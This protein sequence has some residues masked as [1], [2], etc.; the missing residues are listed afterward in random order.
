MRPTE[1]GAAIGFLM[2]F[3]DMRP[4]QQF[5]ALPKPDDDLPV[6]LLM[7]FHQEAVPFFYPAAGCFQM[8]LSPV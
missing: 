7:G 6:F 2:A 4:A 1:K 5:I 8:Q 3:A